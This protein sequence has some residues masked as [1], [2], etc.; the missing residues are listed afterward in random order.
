MTRMVRSLEDWVN[1]EDN[2][3]RTRVGDRDPRPADRLDGD[4]TGVS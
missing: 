1:R 4:E 3:L 2:E